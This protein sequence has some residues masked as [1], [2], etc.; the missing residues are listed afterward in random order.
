MES[1]EWKRHGAEAIQTARANALTVEQA[2]TQE[3]ERVFNRIRE[4]A[5]QLQN[6]EV[7]KEMLQ[8]AQ[9]A[10]DQLQKSEMTQEMLQKAQAAAEVGKEKLRELSETEQGQQVRAAVS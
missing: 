4:A 6:S 2:S 9:D 10:A 1:E 3:L 5:D 7:T 8:K